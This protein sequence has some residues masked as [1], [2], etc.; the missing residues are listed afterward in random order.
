MLGYEIAEPQE[1]EYQTIHLA[2]GTGDGDFTRGP[3]GPA[4]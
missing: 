4:A 3:L 2:L 1:V